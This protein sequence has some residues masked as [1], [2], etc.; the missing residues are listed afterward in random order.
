MDGNSKVL[1][2][3]ATVLYLDS[4]ATSLLSV[5]FPIEFFYFHILDPENGIL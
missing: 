2:A 3:D 1:F 5:I 4:P